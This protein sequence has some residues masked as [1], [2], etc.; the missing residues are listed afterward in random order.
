MIEYIW[1]YYL[2]DVYTYSY[3]IL[4]SK[5]FIYYSSYHLIDYSTRAEVTKRSIFWHLNLQHVEVRFKLLEL[6]TSRG[7]ADFSDGRR[8]GKRELGGAFSPLPLYLPDAVSG[9]GICICRCPRHN[10]VFYRQRH[11]LHTNETS[12]PTV[13]MAGCCLCPAARLPPAA[14][15][16]QLL[17]WWNPYVFRAVI[18]DSRSPGSP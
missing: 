11:T 1:Y 8:Q 2:H 5:F 4:E 14:K 9:T 3:S 16:C 13:D 10:R 7:T 18:K 6:C 12:R 17:C 15:D